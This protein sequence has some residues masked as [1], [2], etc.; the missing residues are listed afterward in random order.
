MEK[1]PARLSITEEKSAMELYKIY[2]DGYQGVI[3]I[4]NLTTEVSNALNTLGNCIVFMLQLEN[5]LVN[6]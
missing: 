1:M 5:N 6:I 2:N 4:P 3:D